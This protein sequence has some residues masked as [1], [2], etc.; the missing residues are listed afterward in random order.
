M[1]AESG[2]AVRVEHPF[3]YLREGRPC[4]L[5]YMSREDLSL[6]RTKIMNLYN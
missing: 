2:I 1:V 6:L 5:N 3:T 4:T